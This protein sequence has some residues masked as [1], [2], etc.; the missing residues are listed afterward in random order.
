MKPTII[1][2]IPAII[3]FIISVILLTLPGSDIPKSTLFETIYFD[4][5]VHIGMF[6]LLTLLFGYPYIKTPLASVKKFTQ[7]MFAV[8]LYGISMEFV[9]K[10]FAS[11]RSFDIFDIMADSVGSFIGWIVL[12]RFLKR[13]QVSEKNE[14]L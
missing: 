6:G 9:Q 1:K 4:K 3:W 10:Y 13:Q 14:P 12:V 2:F 7:I 11:E 8:I 5:W